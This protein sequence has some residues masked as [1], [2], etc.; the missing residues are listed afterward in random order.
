MHYSIILRDKKTGEPYWFE[1]SILPGIFPDSTFDAMLDSVVDSLGLCAKCDVAG[2]RC[3]I[4]DES[5]DE[6]GFCRKLCPIL[7]HDVV[8]PKWR[9]KD[10]V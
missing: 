7:F 5:K 6:N 1:D 3:H 8:R 9:V 2:A 10:V 4:I